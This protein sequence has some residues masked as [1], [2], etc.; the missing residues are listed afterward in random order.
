MVIRVEKEGEKSKEEI[1]LKRINYI[2]I[3]Y[4]IA[5]KTVPFLSLSL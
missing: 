2:H 4:N 5:I 3:Y 1:K